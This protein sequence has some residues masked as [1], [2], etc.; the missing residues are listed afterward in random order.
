[1][2]GQGEIVVLTP[3]FRSVIIT[4]LFALA[5]VFYVSSDISFALFMC[6]APITLRES[7]LNM[8]DDQDRVAYETEMQERL[9]AYEERLSQLELELKP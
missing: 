2:Q 7:L 3:L 6:F 5:L 1:M 9:A 8:E 4:I